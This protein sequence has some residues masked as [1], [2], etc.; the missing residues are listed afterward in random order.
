MA[1]HILERTK[2]S[3]DQVLELLHWVGLD[4][5]GRRLR[6]E[7]ARLFGEPKTTLDVPPKIR[8]DPN[9]TMQIGLEINMQPKQK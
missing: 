1:L 8:Q 2:R 5:L 3:I 4:S 6:L 7:D 9:R